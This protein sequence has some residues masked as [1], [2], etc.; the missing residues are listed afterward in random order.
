MTEK[1]LELNKYTSFRRINW[2]FIT[3]HETSRQRK[4]IESTT[5]SKPH[6]ADE[7]ANLYVLQQRFNPKLHC[8]MKKTYIIA[9][10]RV[11]FRSQIPRLTQVS[12]K[13]ITFDC[14]NNYSW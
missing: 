13:L 14:I 7:Y 9:S 3:A 10:I 12:T 6:Y 1:K 8:C 4:F 2:I 5:L 11:R